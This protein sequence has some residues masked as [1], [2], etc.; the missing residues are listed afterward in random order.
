MASSWKDPPTELLR[1]ILN[2]LPD[3][4]GDKTILACALVCKSWRIV[5]NHHLYG[6]VRVYS[7]SSL[8]KFNRTIVENNAE[9]ASMVKRVHLF[10]TL[11]ENNHEHTAQVYTL[12]TSLPNLEEFESRRSPCFATVKRALR[13][14][15]LNNLKILPSFEKQFTVDYVACILLMRNRLQKLLLSGRGK[16][17]DRVYRQLDRF[18]QLEEIS[19]VEVP[20]GSIPRIDSVVEKCLSLRSVQI[21]F[22]IERSVRFE[23]ERVIASRSSDPET[24]MDERNITP[25]PTIQT[26]RINFQNFRVHE[27]LLSYIMRKYQKL[28]ELRIEN[29]KLEDNPTSKSFIT[30]LSRI[31]D[32]KEVE[33][34]ANAKWFFDRIGSYWEATSVYRQHKLI[35]LEIDLLDAP[36]DCYITCSN[37]KIFRIWSPVSDFENTNFSISNEEHVG[38]FRTSGCFRNMVQRD[39]VTLMESFTT[40]LNRCANLKVV[41][42]FNS[43]ILLTNASAGLRDTNLQELIFNGCK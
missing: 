5:V 32:V 7:I 42:F 9:I 38:N 24:V 16:L 3:G 12:L 23:G 41:E 26:L 15:R 19:I 21:Q 39:G 14:S 20:A 10:V 2:F 43:D 4:R 35:T 31:K 25:R 22:N 33:F 36:D 29:L 30:Y 40:N 18:E 27:I 6:T 37:H 11:H 34:F 28:K 17:F 8:L 13:G 1:S